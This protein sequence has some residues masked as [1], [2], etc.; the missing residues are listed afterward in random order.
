MM[1][2]ILLAFVFV[3]LWF[4]FLAGAPE[5]LV[6]LVCVGIAGWQVGSWSAKISD[7]LL[8]RD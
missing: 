6:G 1:A 8:T 7:Y 2:R 4:V 5:K 3:G